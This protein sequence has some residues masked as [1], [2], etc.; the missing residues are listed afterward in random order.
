[1]PSPVDLPNPGKE[2]GSPAL[3]ADSL[4]AELLRPLNMIE[5]ALQVLA[6]P[7]VQPA[8][9]HIPAE[10]SPTAMAAH[11]KLCTWPSILQALHSTSRI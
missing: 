4:P 6:D 3:Q 1:M 8:C 7:R 2:P 9:H 5:K 10:T 11:P